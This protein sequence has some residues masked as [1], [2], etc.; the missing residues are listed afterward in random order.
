M[1]PCSFP[2]ALLSLFLLQL[3]T[4]IEAKRAPRPHKTQPHT[5]PKVDA[6]GDNIVNV[7]ND[8]YIALV[9]IAGQEYRT[10]LD[11]GST[12]MWVMPP[13]G[14]KL[15]YYDD[16]GVYS[17]I[18]YGDGS[19]YVNGTVGFAKVE[20]AGHTIPSQA[21][22]N[23]FKESQPEDNY[24]GLVGLGFDTPDGSIPA[25]LTKAG[26]D[27]RKLGKSPL[28]SIFDANPHKGRFF[29]LSLSRLW[30]KSYSSD[31]SLTI[32]EY[33]TKYAAVANA[34]VLKQYPKDCGSWSVLGDSIKIGGKVVPWKLPDATNIP[35]G[36]I[37]VLIDSGT[38]NFLVP[39]DVR[40]AIYS[41]VPGAVLSKHSNIEGNKWGADDDIWVV[42]CTTAVN[43]S[44]SF[45]GHEYPI[46]PL[47]LTDVM[48]TTG[49]DGKNY[50]ICVNSVTNGG[51]VISPQSAIFGDSF[52]RNVYTV[53]S[54]GGDTKSDVPYIQFLS[55]TETQK[56]A[57]DF[58]L[59]REKRL[60]RLAKRY[61]AKEL[62]PDKIIALFDSK[63]NTS[64]GKPADDTAACLPAGSDALS[65]SKTEL[66][67]NS[68]SP[69]DVV[70][71]WG[72]I[73]VGLLSANLAILLVVAC[74]SLMSFIRG[75]RNSGPARY[76]KVETREKNHDVVF[77]THTSRSSFSDRDHIGY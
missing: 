44:V 35:N 57:E 45:A 53:L 38:T 47:D 52:M 22:I 18:Y 64:G 73:I 2:A 55:N 13:K 56:A 65:K 46:H 21:F 41:A 75:G 48:S 28:T 9:T 8:R 30:D 7:G 67:E 69:N 29:G 72:P 33:D 70:D 31:A 4:T 39:E 60:A 10:M 27:G 26:M 58:H 37:S 76:A 42:P 5:R 40:D 20:V 24:M 59:H 51:T 63:S 16:T 6:T 1:L 66:S 12:D 50:T 19:D 74:I 77:D 61:N 71:K 14:L 68:S 36:K 54:F 34:P 11:T 15:G 43:M 49:P 25:S 3:T 23:V 32:S 62:S 17:Q